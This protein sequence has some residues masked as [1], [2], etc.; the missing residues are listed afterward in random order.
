MSETVFSST[1]YPQGTSV[2]F[3][4]SVKGLIQGVVSRS[5]FTQSRAIS[6]HPDGLVYVIDVIHPNRGL[7]NF[8]KQPSDICVIEDV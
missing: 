6:T 3:Q 4:H 7:I 8:V 2:S 1:I 5:Y